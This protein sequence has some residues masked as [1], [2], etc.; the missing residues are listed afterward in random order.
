LP[1]H[2]KY[3]EQNNFLFIYCVY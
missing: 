1:R 3:K 2:L